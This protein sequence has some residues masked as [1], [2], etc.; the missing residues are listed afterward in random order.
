MYISRKLTERLFNMLLD[1]LIVNFRVT[2][3]DVAEEF[4]RGTTFNVELSNG[5]TLEGRMFAGGHVTGTRKY[6]P[7]WLHLRFR[8]DSAK[9]LG[10]GLDEE[11]MNYHSFKWNWHP[12][13]KDDAELFYM[14]RVIYNLV[15]NCGLKGLTIL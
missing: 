11:R 14:D 3:P 10:L 13:G 5:I 7:A 2:D 4:R 8:G 15:Q 6:H 9:I 12:S 1:V